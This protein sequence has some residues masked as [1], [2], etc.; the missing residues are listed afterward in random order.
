MF[1]KPGFESVFLREP[2][3]SLRI[4]MRSVPERTLPS[5]KQKCEALEGRRATFCFQIPADF[6]KSEGRDSDYGYK[7]FRLKSPGDVKAIRH[8]AGTLW[9]DGFPRNRE[10]F[11]SIEYSERFFDNGTI[12]DAHG[13]TAMGTRWRQIGHFGESAEYQGVDES[14]ALTLDKILDSVCLLPVRQYTRPELC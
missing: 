1:R 11:E 3:G 2:K 10:V 7:I 13:K 4:V 8:A 5:C 12:L 6:E 9:G 14:T